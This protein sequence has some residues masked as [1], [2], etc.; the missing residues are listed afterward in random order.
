MLLLVLLVLLGPSLT[1]G[2][3]ARRKTSAHFLVQDKRQCHFTNGT[4]QVYLLARY[5]YDRQEIARFDSRLGEY[6]A[7]TET[8]AADVQLW[9]SNKARLQWMQGEVDRFCRYKYRVFENA[10]TTRKVKPTVKIS[11]M[12]PESLAHHSLLLCTASGFYPSEI[13]ITWLKNGQQE[14]D[15]VAYG[16]EL[17]NGDWTYQTQVMLETLVQQGD[18]YTC[19]VEHVSLETPITVQWEPRMSDAARIKVWTGVVGI[20]LGMLSVAVGLYLFLKN[21]KAVIW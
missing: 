9:N 17:Q 7:I 5:I 21:K 13:E 2:S 1:H 20:V 6:V 12:K 14:K 11:L 8:E 16:E 19:Q 18:V 10:V 3:E 4:R 15:G